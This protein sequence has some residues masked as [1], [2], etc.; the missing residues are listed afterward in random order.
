MATLK[1]ITELPLAESAEGVNLIV[2]DNG[3]AK[4]IAVGA[5]GG[6]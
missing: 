1:N 6:V 3:A 4:Q 5:V 2:N